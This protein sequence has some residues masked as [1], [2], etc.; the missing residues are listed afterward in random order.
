VPE[1]AEI[2]QD[3]GSARSAI[4]R[5]GHLPNDIAGQL[6]RCETP[7]L[8]FKRRSDVPKMERRH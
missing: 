8:F 1:L 5:I 7:K 6:T 3:V 2:R 4:R